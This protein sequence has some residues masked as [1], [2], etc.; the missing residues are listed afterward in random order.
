LQWYVEGHLKKNVLLAWHHVAQQQ[1][2][3]TLA[4]RHQQSLEAA[5]AELKAQLGNVIEGLR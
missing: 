5:Q 4:N 2:R 1:H 3:V